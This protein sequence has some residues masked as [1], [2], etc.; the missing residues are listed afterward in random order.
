MNAPR[1]SRIALVFP[2]GQA[3]ADGFYGNLSRLLDEVPHS[4]LEGNALIIR[5]ASPNGARPT[6]A[7]Q[8]TKTSFPKVVFE[9][10][11][12]IELAVGNLLLH[13]S[14]VMGKSLGQPEGSAQPD[15]ARLPM[16]T[17]Y[18]KL[19]RHVCRLDHV[20]V[21]VPASLVD[22]S[23]WGALVQQVA[24]ISTMYRYPTGENWPFILPSTER[25]FQDDIRQFPAGRE[26]K[27][28][29][30][31]DEHAQ[32]PTIQIDVETNL[33]RQE[34]E[35]QFPD[36]YGHALPGVTEYFRSVFVAHP[37][38]GLSIRLDLRFRNDG[39]PDDW[40]TGEW[41]VTEGGRI[42]DEG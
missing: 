23:T 29:L 19:Q 28:E 20:G 1:L 12:P 5:P 21:N 13:S 18:E 4:T 38:P 9:T 2:E 7:V 27:F 17:V 3:E 11:E 34:L 14:S 37:W 36:P 33:T 41:L 8:Q 39:A 42:K 15:A 35:A 30:V 32:E 22:R 16:R 25:E 24:R 31:Y 10:A 6:L 26:P 40:E